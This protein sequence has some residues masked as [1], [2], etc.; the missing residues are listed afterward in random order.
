VDGG[1]TASYSSDNQNRRY[2][3]T[4]GSTVT[5]YVWEGSQVLAEHNGSTGAV[6][7][8]YVYSGSRMIAKVASGTAQYSLSDR[9]STRLVLDTTGNVLGRQGHLQFG[10]DFGESGTQEK[11]HFTS[12]E[13]DSESSTDYGLNRQYNQGVGRFNRPDPESE[14]CNYG[15]PQSLNRYAYVKGDPINRVDPL[16]LD[17]SFGESGGLQIC[18]R[19]P[20]T[21]VMS[22]EFVLVPIS[23]GQRKRTPRK[24]LC[25]R[26]LEIQSKKCV[27]AFFTCGADADR[28]HKRA[29][30]RCDRIDD[31]ELRKR[32]RHGAGEVW[33]G[34]VNY[35]IQ[36][37]DACDALIHEKCK[38]QCGTD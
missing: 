5:H 30:R 6:L 12:Y 23:R 21:E 8:D 4:I 20:D 10:E 33:D 37:R 3:K 31:V 15:T 1:S 9:L 2:K 36:L 28:R 24:T 32:C 25:D 17:D 22:C 26:C 14:S 35:C 27:D 29:L 13:R 7:I 11:H 19:D 38:T 18:E 16:G 34:D